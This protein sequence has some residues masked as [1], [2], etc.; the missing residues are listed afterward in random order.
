MVEHVLRENQHGAGR[1]WGTGLCQ[2][3]GH[4]N[5]SIDAIKKEEV[6]LDPFTESKI[7]DIDMA[8]SRRGFLHISHCGAAVII[9]I[10]EC[11]C[12][13]WDVKIPE[14]APN[15]RII[16][17]VSHAAI[18]SAS[19]EDPATVGWNLHLYAMVPPV[20]RTH[21]PPK[22]RHVFTHVAQSKSA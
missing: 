11:R 2:V 10:E 21:T 3:I 1:V 9:F 18:N 6:A 20:S 7:F 13:L 12:F 14:Y 17:P 19:V 15:K 8:R 4:V 5:R 16:F 22:E